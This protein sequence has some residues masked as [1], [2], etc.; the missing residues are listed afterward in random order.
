MYSF[1]DR[2]IAK[3]IVTVLVMTVL[4]A[5]MTPPVSLGPADAAPPASPAGDREDGPEEAD[6]AGD[7]APEGVPESG[8][9]PWDSNRGDRRADRPELGAADP[10]AQ[11]NTPEWGHHAPGDPDAVSAAVDRT[12]SE[13]TIAEKAGQLIMPALSHDTGGTAV[14]GMGEELAAL[15]DELQPGGFLLFAPN[16]R[17]PEQTRALV[18]EMH[19]RVALPLL[20]AV[21]QE[22]GIVRRVVPGEAMPATDIPA[23]SVVGR[24]GD[25]DLARQLG[26]VIARELQSLGI[27]VD[28]APVADVLTNPANP[29]VGSRAYGRDPEVVGTFVDSTVRGL[30][31]GGVAAVV[32]HFPGHGDTVQD[33]HDE[34]ATVDHDL[35]RLQEVELVPFRRAIE[36]GVKGVMVGHISV[37]EVSGAPVPATI[38]P[39]IVTGLLRERLGYD[40][41]VV[42]DSLTM[43]ALTRYYQDAETAIRAVEAGVDVL[44]QPRRPLA[45]RDAIVAAVASGRLPEERLDQSV[46][47]VLTLKVDLDLLQVVGDR[48]GAVLLESSIAFPEITIGTEEHHAVVETIRARARETAR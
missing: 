32:K 15:L 6:R 40:G 45:V 14:T 38:D 34:A 19:D 47:R 22:G 43:A 1:L 18:R 21:D 29:V 35:A 33:S 4:G 23:A 30:Q 17:S 27:T 8:S 36:A 3:I 28:F 20:V 5:C 24:S 25:P 41:L 12:L 31:S 44:L 11:E 13:M 42:T 10:A 39:T 2:G 7:E 37:P 48:A 16:I 9:A 46:R 26:G